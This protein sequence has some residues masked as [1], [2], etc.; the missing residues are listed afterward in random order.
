MIEDAYY[1]LLEESEILFET[2]MK[3][4]DFDGIVEIENENTYYGS[5]CEDCDHDVGLKTFQLFHRPGVSRWNELIDRKTMA[6]E[7]QMINTMVSE[8]LALLL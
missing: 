5:F 8:C 1:N 4:Q 2:R 3:L 6:K 7:S